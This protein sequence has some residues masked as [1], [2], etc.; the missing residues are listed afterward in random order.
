[1]NLGNNHP[2]I[3]TISLFGE[4]IGYFQNFSA[5]A[6]NPEESKNQAAIKLVNFLTTELQNK[7][8]QKL[9]LKKLIKGSSLLLESNISKQIYEAVKLQWSQLG[10][11]NSLL[12]FKS[13]AAF[14]ITSKLDKNFIKVVSIGTGNQSNSSKTA[15]PYNGQVVLDCHAEVIARRAFLCFLY[16]QIGILLDN[17]NNENLVLDIGTQGFRMKTN[18]Q[19]HLYS[20]CSPCTEKCSKFNLFKPCADK[21]KIWNVLGVQGAILSLFLE[22]LYINSVVVSDLSNFNQLTDELYDRIDSNLLEAMLES[23]Q[24]NAV[25]KINRHKIGYFKNLNDND[26]NAIVSFY[27]F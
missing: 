26:F 19:L 5:S 13:L 7:L 6:S 27:V 18:L 24:L 23:V 8:E 3:T 9:N 11:D 22:P 4:T 25:Y 17:P 21:L 15:L 2:C 10:I 16:N 12:K 20:N 14:V 1:M